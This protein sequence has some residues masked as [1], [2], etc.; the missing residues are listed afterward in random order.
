MVRRLKSLVGG[1]A[2]MAITVG[3]L[4]YLVETDR[5]NF[6]LL[7][8]VA[9][10]PWVLVCLFGIM[11]AN[12]FMASYRWK[13]LLRGQQLLVPYRSVFSMAMIGNFFNATLPGAV[14]GDLVKFY[15]LAKRL[16]GIKKTEGFMTMLIDRVVGLAGLIFISMAV[17]I[18]FPD[19]EQGQRL[20]TFTIT[21]AIIFGIFFLTILLPGEPHRKLIQRILGIV[22][23]S[24]IRR[25]LQKIYLA[26]DAYKH[27]PGQF[28]LTICLS[29]VIHTLMIGAFVIA[30]KALSVEVPLSILFLVVPLGLITTAIPIAPGGL[31]VGHLA[32]EK[33]FALVGLSSGADL[34]N[35]VVLCQ[36]ATNLCGGIF[37]LMGKSDQ[38]IKPDQPI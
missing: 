30:A 9:S 28:L 13:L 16:P 17:L 37:Y 12:V 8:V 2:K 11:W 34:F 22:P 26:A 29:M 36:L 23:V 5:L 10:Q 25:T 1:L 19:S 14:S 27:M 7:K 35:V 24:V 15:Y 4:F 21:M 38:M 31:G 20:A 6:Q 18:E 32:F 33:L 3:I